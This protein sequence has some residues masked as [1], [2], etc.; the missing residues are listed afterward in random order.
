MGA[1]MQQRGRKSVASLAVMPG[2]LG[3][4]PEP[5][6]DTTP[7]QADLWR[8]IAASEHPDVFRSEG[9]RQLLLQFVR[10]AEAADGLAKAIDSFDQAY[11]AT[12][13]GLQLYDRILKLRD[14]ETKAMATL[15]TR[16][17]L[18]AQA[19]FSAAKASTMAQGAGDVLKPW[20]ARR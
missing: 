12:K 2:N 5:P 8:R 6:H 19:R 18:T 17:R 4:R 9:Q 3:D 11:I 1:T 16:M 10:H 15:A 13:E 7:F 14:R 20:Q